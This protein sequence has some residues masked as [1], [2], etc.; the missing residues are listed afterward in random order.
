L[1]VVLGIVARFLFSHFFNSTSSPLHLTDSSVQ[2]AVVNIIGAFSH[3]ITQTLMIFGAIYAGI[4]IIT[5]IIL[6]FTKSKASAPVDSSLE[7]RRAAVRNEA[8]R[9]PS[10]SPSAD[11][12]HETETNS[13]LKPK[14]NKKIQL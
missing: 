1:L 9:R 12:D 6:H 4:G 2:Q 7:E 10:G 8:I 13:D 11:G 5:L 3:I 14:P